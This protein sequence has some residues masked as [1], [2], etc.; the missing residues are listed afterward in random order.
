[1]PPDELRELRDRSSATLAFDVAAQSSV[2]VMARECESSSEQC[3]DM[4]WRRRAAARPAKVR[5]MW[6]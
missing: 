2:D 6:R 5:V 4:T 3:I 1:M